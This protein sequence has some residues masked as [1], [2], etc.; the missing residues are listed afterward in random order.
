MDAEEDPASEGRAGMTRVSRREGRGTRAIL[1]PGA[2]KHVHL[3]IAPHRRADVV[4]D[5]LREWSG[6]ATV[7]KASAARCP[8]R[9]RR[10]LVALR[11]ADGSVKRCRSSFVSLARSSAGPIEAR[12]V[13]V[14]SSAAAG[15]TKE[16]KASGVESLG[17]TVHAARRNSARSSRYMRARGSSRSL[18]AKAL[19][20]SEARRAA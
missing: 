16:G 2:G 6:A 10:G 9:E 1:L 5:S 3:V 13:S 18:A 19:R 4:V 20:T 11:S 14:D 8:T 7:S 15:G 17:A 12:L